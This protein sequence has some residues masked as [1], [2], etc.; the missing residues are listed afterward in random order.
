ML[1]ARAQA[2]ARLRAELDDHGGA[3]EAQ[4]TDSGNTLK[5]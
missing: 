5:P 1:Y 4:E 2:R 3:Q